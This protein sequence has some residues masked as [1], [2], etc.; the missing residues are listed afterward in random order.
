MQ[1]LTAVSPRSF[2]TPSWKIE[3]EYSTRVLTGNWV[4]ERRTFTKA[5]EKTPQS[6]YRKE[7]VPFPCHR[8]DQIS[9]WY[10]KRRVEGLPYKHLITHNQEPSHCHLISSYDDHYNRH[11]Y[12]LGLPPCRSWS[13]HKLLWLPEK[14]DFPLL[15]ILIIQGFLLDWGV[16]GPHLHRAEVCPAHAG[17]LARGTLAPGEC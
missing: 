5:T 3:A 9:R 1:F 12:N 6:I 10:T 16:R 7:Y 14:A 4:E 2:Y 8:P 17:G 13:G 11:N 15:G